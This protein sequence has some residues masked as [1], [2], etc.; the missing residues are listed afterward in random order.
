MA[1]LLFINLINS[2]TIKYT[3]HS[4][5]INPVLIPEPSRVQSIDKFLSE[6][7]CPPSTK[8]IQIAKKSSTSKHNSHI[9]SYDV[10]SKKLTLD[11]NFEQFQLVLL[12]QDNPQ[13]MTPDRR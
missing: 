6:H 1:S 3:H 2:N 8:S 13:Y 11:T 4:I 9:K 5:I 7:L 12:A 10:G